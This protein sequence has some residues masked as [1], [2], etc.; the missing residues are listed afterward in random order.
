MLTVNF[1]H[2][3]G[4]FFQQLKY[5]Y[6]AQRNNRA[7]EEAF[8]CN[9]QTSPSTSTFSFTQNRFLFPTIFVSSLTL[10]SLVFLLR[11]VSFSKQAPQKNFIE[12]KI[13]QKLVQRQPLPKPDIDI[14]K[15]IINPVLQKPIISRET[16]INQPPLYTLILNK[17]TK[18]LFVTKEIENNYSLIREFPV[19]FG[20][21]PGNK[22]RKGDQ[23]TPEGI[24]SLVD[25]KLDEELPEK[26]G[27]FAAVLNYPNKADLKKGKTGDG[28][29][30][31]GTGKDQLTP[32]TQ[33]CIELSDKHLLQLY[34][35]IG[36]G[37]KIIIASEKIN[38]TPVR[39][40]IRGDLVKLAT[41]S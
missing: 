38:I 8:I 40:M 27:P 29:W 30:I 23:K 16:F 39:K 25:L 32:D 35:Y 1:K 3:A 31:H 21:V 13:Q 37:V 22:E 6:I 15:V 41:I 7:V 17:H 12:K 26:Y 36:K 18:K 14:E 28:I 4:L 10:L 20:K 2:R 9:L 34:S 11:P 5:G 19:S 24:Y 33:G